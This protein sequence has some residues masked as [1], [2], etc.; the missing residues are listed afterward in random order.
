MRSLTQMMLALCLLFAFV[1]I[2]S[3]QQLTDQ[4][5]QNLLS[6]VT[7]STN[8]GTPDGAPPSGENACNGLKGAAHGLC[9]AYCEAMDCGSVNAQASQKAC[10]KVGA[11]F[12]EITGQRPPCDFCPCMAAVPGFAESLSQP[13]TFCIGNPNSN[14]VFLENSTGFWPFAVLQPPNP[15]F[16]GN[17]LTASGP[18]ITMA[19]AASCQAILRQ[20]AAAQGVT[21][22]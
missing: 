11:H 7:H 8:L 16:C 14:I 19:Q 15:S 20:T 21:C 9:T 1:S 2:A 12:Q 13:V 4:Q 6:R 10:D 5:I 17:V 22:F 18:E 3:A